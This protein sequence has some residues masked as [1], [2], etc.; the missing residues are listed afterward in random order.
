MKFRRKPREN[1][2]I[3]LASLIDVVFILLL[4]F[5]V[6]TTFTRETQLKVDLPEAASGTPPEQTELKQVEV[7]IGAD[8]AYSVNGKALLESNLTNLMAALQKESDGDN[9]LPLI[10]SADGKT[11]HQAVITAMDAAGKL[12][13]SHLRITTVEA[14]ENP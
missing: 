6:T 13:F 2:E 14:Q 3:N 10:I 8:G 11:P 1:V 4:F 12:G 5:V 7:L 9:S